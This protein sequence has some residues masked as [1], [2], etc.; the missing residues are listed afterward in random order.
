MQGAYVVRQCQGQCVGG[1]YVGQCSDEAMQ[2]A[3]VVRQCQGQCVGGAYA[4]QCSDE[5]EVRMWSSTVV[6]GAVWAVR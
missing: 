4:G 3:Y 5:A 2:G 1:A 6:V